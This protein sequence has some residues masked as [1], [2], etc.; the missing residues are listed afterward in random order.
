[1]EGGGGGIKIKN[2]LNNKFLGKGRKNSG[3]RAN[4]PPPNSKNKGNHRQNFRSPSLSYTYNDEGGGGDLSSKRIKG[5]SERK[6][7]K[8]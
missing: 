5:G 2:M 8:K 3:R 4:Q 6:K 7:Q 1:V